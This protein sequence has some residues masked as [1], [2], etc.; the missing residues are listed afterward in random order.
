MSITLTVNGKTY[1]T[2]QTEK[3]LLHYLREDLGLV[4]SKDGCSQGQC[5]TCTVIVNGKATRSC[6]KKLKLLDGAVVETIEGIA[7]NGELHPLQT[8][9]LIN[10]AYQCGFCTPG[11]IMAC[12]ALLDENPHPT[13]PEIKKHLKNNLCR[14]TGYKLILEAVHIA[15]EILDGKRPNRVDN[16]TGWVG[17]RPAAKHGVERVTGAPI[18]TDD[19]PLENA[20]QG[21]LLFAQYPHANIHGIDTSEAEKLPGVVKIITHKDIPGRKYFAEEEFG[22]VILAIDKVHYIGDPVAIVIADTVE[23]ADA[24]TKAIKV[25]YEV[26]PVIATAED[27]LDPNSVRVHPQ[28]PNKYHTS[29]AVKGDVEKGFALADLIVEQE[30]ETQRVEHGILEMDVSLA[31]YSEDGRIYLYGTGQNPTKIKADV[32]AALNMTEDQIRY[33]NRPAGGAFGGREDLVCQIF[34]ALGTYHTKQP[35]RIS[36][37]RNQISAFTPKRHPIKFKYKVGVKKDG[38]ITAIQGRALIDSGANNSLGDFLATC[39]AAMGSGPYNVP[40][41]DFA[42]TVV[43]TNNTFGGCFRGYGSTQ[44][45]VCNET[46]MDKVAEKIGMD[47]FEFRIKNGLEIGLQTPAG[48]IIDYSCGFKDCLKAVREA[49]EK[50]GIPMPSGE[51][52]KIGV[53]LAG[54]MKNQGYGNG[55]EDGAGTKIM[56]TKDGKFLMHTGAVECGQ[57]VDTI[58]CQIAAQTLGVRYD[59]VDIGPVDDDVSPYSTGSTSASRATYGYGNSS[60]TVSLMLKDKLIKYAAEKLH[61]NASHLEMGQD[62]LYSI[63]DDYRISYQDLAAIAQSNGDVL[64]AE[65]YWVDKIVRPLSENGDNLTNDP[66]QKVYTAYIFS[67]QIAVV[68]VDELTGEVKVLKMYAAS[69]MGKAINPGLVEGQIVGGVVMGLGY[70]LTESFEQDGG[71]IVPKG[72]KGLKMPT[73]EDMPEIKGFMVEENHPFGPYGAKGF[74]EGSLNP[75]APAVLNAIY[76]A[77]GVRVSSIPVNKERLAKAIQGDKVY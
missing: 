43:F 42:S 28:F 69:D 55:M 11:M 31:K 45:T 72:L 67:A 58:I 71:Y 16:G 13:D 51:H 59:D 44:V 37:T 73:I 56:L 29:K 36:L 21:R 22:Q 20:L 50:D 57:G 62:G 10:H 4:G 49:F 12:K 74:S 24:A 19:F 25:D 14:C 17:E 53:G 34:A 61:K 1:T 46:L 35:V 52:K 66:D 15:I 65:Y 5:G 39:T 76:N 54:A 64:E 9:F 60:R 38:T 40:N 77:V 26:L 48:Q 41:T 33:I 18:F 47:P 63:V 68:E 7:K 3:T 23:H 32:L 27:G 8:A 30:F 70:C 6:I 2:D 75:A